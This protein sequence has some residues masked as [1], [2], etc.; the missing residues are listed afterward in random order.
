MTY[1]EGVRGDTVG[2][3]S[4]LAARGELAAVEAAVATDGGRERWRAVDNQGWCALHHAAA[5]GQGEVVRVLGAAGEGARWAG[6]G[7]ARPPMVTTEAAPSETGSNSEPMERWRLPLLLTPLLDCTLS[8]L[9]HFPS[10]AGRPARPSSLPGMPGVAWFHDS[11]L[12]MDASL[13]S[14]TF[15]RSSIVPAVWYLLVSGRSP[16][17]APRRRPSSAAGSA[18]GSEITVI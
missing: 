8:L 2:S 18:A 5:A 7:T 17:P 4:V 14:A 10:L 6:G 3:L 1:F 13:P 16:R 11:R 12:W 15:L 9:R